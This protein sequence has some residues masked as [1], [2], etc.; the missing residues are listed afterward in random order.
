MKD[1]VNTTALITGGAGGMGRLWAEHF[2]KD[3]ASVVLWDLNADSLKKTAK[4]LNAAFPG[5]VRSARCDITN[6]TA[7]YR[8]AKKTGPVDIL[9]N[10]AGIVAGGKFLDTDDDKLAATINV[11]LQSVMWTI[12]A[13]LPG[14][15]SRK[16]GHIVN[17][18]SAAGFLGTPFMAPYNASKWG[19]IGLTESLK[20]EMEE[21]NI[22]GIRFTLV[23]PSYVDTGMFNGV[24]APL[25]VPLLN[26]EKFVT[27]AYGAFRKNR[28][29][30]MA[31]F[32]VNFI[33][34]LRGI[35]PI[36]MFNVIAKVLG[37]TRSMADWKGRGK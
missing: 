37:V 24:K 31:P 34:F 32:M 27:A 11:N 20:L 10:N 7:V 33:P 12:K 25:L 23:C 30:V 36:G 15:I 1:I 4:E 3:G 21:L 16:N 6:R 29:L 9:V 14:M 18:S 19:I 35:M 28:Y 5:K 26:P 22:K 2:L 13:F 17:I 8:E